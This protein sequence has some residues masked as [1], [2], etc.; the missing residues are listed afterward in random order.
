ME[1][2]L[3]ELPFPPAPPF[4]PF[5]L[6]TVCLCFALRKLCIIRLNFI[7]DYLWPVFSNFVGQK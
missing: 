7:N 3:P 5:F 1:N 2:I 6:V 4:A